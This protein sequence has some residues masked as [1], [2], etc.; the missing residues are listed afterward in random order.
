MNIL[1]KYCDQLGTVKILE[2]LELKLPYISQV[3][4][5]LECLPFI[6]C[7]DDEAA[8][9]TQCLCT[10]KRNNVRPPV[11]WKQKLD[12]Q[13]RTGEFQKKLTDGLREYI[14]KKKY[15]VICL[16]RSKKYCNVG[17]LC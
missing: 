9:E 6:Y 12:E 5:P 14:Y 11:G 2:S 17:S 15:L 8:M 3:N 7:Q 1:Y 10:F 4:D 16:A 13:I